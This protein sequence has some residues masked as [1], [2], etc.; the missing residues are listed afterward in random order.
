MKVIK[1]LILTISIA[2]T[3]IF[4]Y[5][6][7]RDYKEYTFKIN[8]YQETTGKVVY[9]LSNSKKGTGIIQYYIGE[10]IYRKSVIYPKKLKINQKITILYNKE[11]P[12]DILFSEI[13]MDSTYLYLAIIFVLID[14]VLILNI[15]RS[16][17]EKIN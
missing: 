9:L 2:L 13:K 8:N 4:G 14:I 1:I 12:T 17:Y 6:Y 11:D 3:I 16:K 10:T 15:A 5:T 7:Y